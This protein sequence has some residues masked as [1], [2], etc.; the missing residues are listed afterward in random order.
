MLTQDD[1]KIF[2]AQIEFMAKCRG[3]LSNALE[4]N[5]IVL[6]EM[7]LC[8]GENYIVRETKSYYLVGDVWNTDKTKAFRFRKEFEGIIGQST[9]GT[10]IMELVGDLA[11]DILM[12]LGKAG[13]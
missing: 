12:G 9:D 6:G 1:Q 10:E 7:N 13:A 8:E 2:K 5:G 11:L 4:K 3:L